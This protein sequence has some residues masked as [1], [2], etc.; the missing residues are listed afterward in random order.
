MS[1]ENDNGKVLK[2][3][4]KLIAKRQGKKWMD[5]CSFWHISEPGAT[6]RIYSKDFPYSKNIHELAEFLN[7]TVNDILKGQSKPTIQNNQINDKSEVYN[8]SIAKNNFFSNEKTELAVLRAENEQLKIIID[9]QD[10]EIEFLR[11]QLS[12]S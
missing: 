10:K 12:R 8:Q 6:K 9:K 11:G 1:S 7:C 3:R 5:I 4:I 2:N